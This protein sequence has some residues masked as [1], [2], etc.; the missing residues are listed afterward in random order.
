M[1][2]Y[3]FSTFVFLI[4]PI[5][6]VIFRFK[7]SITIK[8]LFIK[9]S[10][11]NEK[12][13]ECPLASTKESA[14]EFLRFFSHVFSTTEEGKAELMNVTQYAVLGIVPI[15]ALNKLIQRFVPEADLEK[16]SIVSVLGSK[17]KFADTPATTIF[18]EYM[19][20]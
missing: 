9:F 8:S 3:T 17:I 19:S 15:F 7:R 2:N 12:E 14:E 13:I 16:S 6:Y 5:I 18:H 11:L 4:I 10:R 20:N 1:N